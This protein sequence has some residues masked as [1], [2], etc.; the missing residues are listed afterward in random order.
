MLWLFQSNGSEK[1]LAKEGEAHD[2]ESE[3]TRL[4]TRVS[5]SFLA[6]ESSVCMST[7][8]RGCA[9]IPSFTPAGTSPLPAQELT[10][11]E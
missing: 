4:P 1:E 7:E 5:M 8:G 6:W 10:M 9:Q 3:A 2:C 11:N